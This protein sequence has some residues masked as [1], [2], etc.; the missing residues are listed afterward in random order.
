MTQG[1]GKIFLYRTEL[2]LPTFLEVL[3]SKYVV[4]SLRIL[5]EDSQG[6]DTANTE[7]YEAL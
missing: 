7:S 4:I 6:H 5:D 2:S 3:M 1:Y